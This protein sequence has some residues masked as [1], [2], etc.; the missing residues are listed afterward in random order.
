MNFNRK[1]LKKSNKII[2]FYQ[3]NNYKNINNFKRSKKNY[4]MKI[5]IYKMKMKINK[6]KLNNI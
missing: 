5:L 2:K 1:I 4:I 3:N 6:K